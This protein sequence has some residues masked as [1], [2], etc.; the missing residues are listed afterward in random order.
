MRKYEIGL[1]NGLYHDKTNFR[2]M[3]GQENNQEMT[4]QTVG[5]SISFCHLALIT[6]PRTMYGNME[7]AP[8]SSTVVKTILQQ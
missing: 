5:L 8:V 4:N 7:P 3:K 6:A 2:G 1:K